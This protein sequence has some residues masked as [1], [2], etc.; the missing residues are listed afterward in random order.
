MCFRLT[1]L[2]AKFVI[3]VDNN[4]IILCTLWN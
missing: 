2:T 4:V 1:I 3:V